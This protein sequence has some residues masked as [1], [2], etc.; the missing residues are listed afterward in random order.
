LGRAKFEVASE[1][2]SLTTKVVEVGLSDI[3]KIKYKEALAGL[4]SVGTKSGNPED[5]EVTKLTAV[6]YC[7]QIVN[8]PSLIDCEGESEKL[9][10]LL[11]LLTEGDLV[12][13][14]VI[15]F[16]RFRKMI[17]IIMLALAKANIKAVRITGSENEDQREAAQKAFQDLN[18]ETK[19]ICITTAGSDAINLQAAK[20]MILYD[21]PWSAGEFL[22]LIGRMIRIGSIYDRCYAIHLVAKRTI[23]A[24]IMQ[25]QKKK[26]ALIEAVL[27]KRIKG[28]GDATT[29]I[30]VDNDIS[31]LFNSLKEDVLQEDSEVDDGND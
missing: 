20:A 1:L 28:D 5:K 3:Q 13:E 24:K 4:L 15:V 11:E 8:H 7:Q 21:T 19:V 23:D 12:G 22:Q 17:D 6:T 18:G 27:G 10:A 30:S 2:P 9:D 16:S 14:K 31:D 25:V 26:M 29:V